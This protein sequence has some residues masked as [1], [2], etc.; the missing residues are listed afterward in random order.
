MACSKIFFPGYTF[1][2]GIY[3]S[4]YTIPGRMIKEYTQINKNSEITEAFLFFLMQFTIQTNNI[5]ATPAPAN[6]AVHFVAA[7]KAKEAPEKTRYLYLSS[8]R[9]ATIP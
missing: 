6:T 5:S 1:A 9:N 3:D 4:T 8:W 2:K 7:P